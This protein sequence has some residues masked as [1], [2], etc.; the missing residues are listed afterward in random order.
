MLSAWNDWSVDT[1]TNEDERL[2]CFNESGCSLLLVNNDPGG[3]DE[4]G[5]TSVVAEMIDGVFIACRKMT[6]V[7]KVD[8][9]LVI[10]PR[11]Y[12]LLVRTWRSTKACK[13]SNNVEE[14]KGI[15]IVTL[16]TECYMNQAPTRSERGPYN[17]CV[18]CAT[19]HLSIIHAQCLFCCRIQ[20]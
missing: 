3:D 1:N 7:G 15:F 18:F 9:G 16:T 2:T 13:I 5:A 8:D 6:S 20:K 12:A 10:F 14:R 19:S 17:L 11:E 4:E